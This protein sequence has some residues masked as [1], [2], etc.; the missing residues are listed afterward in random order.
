MAPI[1]V[2]VTKDG[3]STAKAAAVVG[4]FPGIWRGTVVDVG[5][6]SR[7]LEGQLPDLTREYIGVDLTPPA[8]VVADLGR[9]LPFEDDR[10]EV[11]VALDVLEHVDDIHTAF[12]E[13]CRVAKSDLVISLP[14]VYDL[15]LR[16]RMVRGRP[17]S[18]KYGLPTERPTDRHRWFFTFTEAR[19]FCD[20]LGRE[21][22]WRLVDEVALVGPRRRSL[23][24]A[25]ERYPDLLAPTYLAR[26][27]HGS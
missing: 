4:A 24:S 13:L 7:E 11:A 9:G 23:G 21:R 6:R 25:I 18:G 5:C 22:G 19:R 20:T 27:H 1:R 3:G 14:N 15:L 16:L 12:G 10:A 17:L 2:V 8:D 26:L